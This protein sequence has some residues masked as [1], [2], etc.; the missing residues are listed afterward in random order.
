[1]QGAAAGALSQLAQENEDGVI[2]PHALPLL[3]AL[4]R[5]DQPAVDEAAVSAYI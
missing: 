5:S 1:M 3:V 2:V 4:V